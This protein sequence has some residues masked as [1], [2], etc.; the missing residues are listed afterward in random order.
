[1]R[2][3]ST[4]WMRKG[5]MIVLNRP[6]T[7]APMLVRRSFMDEPD[8]F[9]HATCPRLAVTGQHEIGLDRLD[10]LERFASSR[11]VAPEGRELRPG[12]PRKHVQRCERVSYEER[13]SSGQI[14][15]RAAFAVAREVDHSGRAGHVEARS[16]AEGGNLEDGR[17]AKHPLR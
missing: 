9:G 12:L 5:S 6:D 10:S 15:R 1:M 3:G 4:E 14:Q 2:S 7:S 8:R 11:K 17:R 16:V 13:L